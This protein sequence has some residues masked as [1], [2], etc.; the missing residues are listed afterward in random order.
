MP[1]ILIVDDERSIQEFFAIM[2]GKEGFEYKCVGSGEEA[3]HEVENEIFDLVITDLSMS[4]ISGMEVLQKVKQISPETSVILITA[5]G[6]TETAVEA[7]KLGALDYISKPFKLEEIKLTIRKAIERSQLWREN[8]QL[9]NELSSR[10]GLGGLIGSCKSMQ[11]VFNAI[12]HLAKHRSNVLITGSSGTG[13]ELVARAIHDRGVRADLPFVSVNCGAIPENLIESELFGYMRGAFTGATNNKRGLLEAAGDGT[14]F[15]DEVGELPLATQVKLL[16]VLQERKIR[17]VGGVEDIGI[18]CRILAATNRD[19][20]SE[21]K[22]GRFRD[23]LYYRLNV[24]S[25][26]LPELQQRKA[27]IPLLV[28]HFVNKYEKVHQVSV[29]HI[30]EEAMRRFELFNY[31]GNV[32]QLES[33]V[34]QAVAMSAGDVIEVRHLPAILRESASEHDTG[35]GGLT[36]V[37]ASAL[38]LTRSHKNFCLTKALEDYERSILTQALEQAGGVKKKAAKLLNIS[39]RSIRYRLVKLGVEDPE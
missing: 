5:Y 34:E 3:V 37:Q 26:S 35:N 23:D 20:A 1:K 2:I 10:V 30:D 39:F 4:G 18:N 11:Q 19:L 22:H 7:M 21:V 33:F 38:D 6:D 12:N 31:P 14:F 15:F 36:S 28:K 25:V 13:K 32:R 16:R 8:E 9:K 17:R 24:F 27:D 29:K